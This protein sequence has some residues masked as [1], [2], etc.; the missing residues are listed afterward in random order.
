MIT[1]EK[2]PEQVEANK[3]NKAMANGNYFDFTNNNNVN[4][5]SKAVEGTIDKLKKQLNEMRFL[6]E[7][8]D[9]KLK[10]KTKNLENLTH[11]RNKALMLLKGGVKNEVKSKVINEN[12][13]F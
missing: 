2:T 5:M 1:F 12:F 9:K 4:I 8:K 6:M 10:Q 11:Q 13:S 7:K 3:L